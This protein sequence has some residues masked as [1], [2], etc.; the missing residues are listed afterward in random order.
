MYNLIKNNIPTFTII[1]SVLFASLIFLASS[2]GFSKHASYVEVKGL[3]ERIVKAD[4][5]V[6]SL[7]FD[8][9]S[10]NIE[11]LYADIERNIE[12]TKKFLLSKG[13][14]ESEISVAPIN[15]YQDTY[16]EA[17]YRFN[18]SVALSVYTDK[19]DLV[20]SASGDTLPLIKK[21]I[22]MNSN[23]AN[24]EFSQINDIK[25]EMLA[26]AIA[27]AR[28]SAKQFADDAGTR[29][30]KIARANQGVF[31]ISDKDPASPEYKKI[32]IVS[33]IRFLLK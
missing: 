26:D 13:F 2:R 17:L 8:A 11:S 24:Y 33:T 14:E 23:Y 18:S 19:V 32:R 9:K 25:P 5:V 12:T 4:V 31:D 27:N 16:S 28:V 3:S 21:G 22:V 1:V 10:N 30:G 15:I 20:R 7:S 29:I 6:W